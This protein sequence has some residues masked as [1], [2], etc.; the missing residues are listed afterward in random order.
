M[1]LGKV[2]IGSPGPVPQP[3]PAHPSPR[4]SPWQKVRK[5]G[6]QDKFFLPYE[7]ILVNFF[8]IYTAV[9]ETPI[10]ALLIPHT[11]IVFA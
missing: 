6:E 2:S 10:C 7:L 5:V 9:C 8:S 1:M 4:P 11:V 3:P